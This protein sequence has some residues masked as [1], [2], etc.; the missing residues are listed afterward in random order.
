MWTGI[1][2]FLFKN[3][4]LLLAIVAISTIFMGF[5]ARKTSL[6]YTFTNGIPASNPVSQNFQ[7]LK[8]IFGDDASNMVLAFTKEDFFS[9]EFITD[10]ESFQKKLNSIEG[11]ENITSIINTSNLKISES[12]GEKKL[13]SEPFFSTEPN[14]DLEEV[15]KKV[16]K[17]KFYEGLLFNSETNAYL[18]LLGLDSTH[19]NSEQRNELMSSIADASRSFGEAHETDLKISGLPY[20]RTAMAMMVQNEMQ[21]F[22]ILSLIV[23]SLILIFLFRSVGLWLISLVYMGIGIIWG[24]G[25]MGILGFK[26]TLLTAL[27]APL[28]VIISV[29]NT[30]YFINK[31]HSSY[32]ETRDKS[33]SLRAMVEKIGIV[34]LFTNLTTA[35]GFGVFSLTTSQVL[36]EFGIVAGLTIVVLFI[37]A[38]I[39]LPIFLS[40]LPAPK[41]HQLKYMQNNWSRRLF[42]RIGK[43]V[44]FYRRALYV[45]AGV[46]V[47]IAILG[48]LRLN[49]SSYIVDDLPHD[50]KLYKDLVFFD[51][52]FG[53]VMPLEIIIDTRKKN[54]ATS[55]GTLN[56]TDRLSTYISSFPYISRPLSIV[57]GIKFA[58]QAYYD[59]EPS[60]YGMPNSLDISFFAPYLSGN[61]GEK[62]S[63]FSN[64]V[65]STK[66]YSRVSFRMQDIGTHR[67]DSF[68]AQLETEIYSVFDSSKYHVFPSGTSV[69]FLE[70]SKYIIS[71]LKSSVLLAFLFIFGCIFYLFK[72]WR[73]LLISMVVNLIPLVITAGIM[74]WVA[75]RIKPSTVLVF[76]IALGITVDMT[77]RFLINFKQEIEQNPSINLRK[78]VLN[79]ISEA[80][81]SIIFTTF[82]LAFGFGVFILSSFDGTRSLGILIPLT[83]INAMISNLTLLPALLLEMPQGYLN[84]MLG[85][86]KIL[87]D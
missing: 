47:V 24:F 43:L 3:K 21:Y 57:E 42:R 12:Q 41:T 59:G 35:L 61:Q 58:R 66:R 85:Q 64:F 56:K 14:Q 84:K 2:D 38:I 8:N 71:S 73:M 49:T 19:A 55:F 67:M 63:V 70:G 68:I 40:F 52:N 39:L 69:T 13:I 32:L 15:K 60:G 44:I 83:I 74:G 53:G 80:G 65:D 31:Y 28:V 25:I 75:I 17:T 72:N 27:L 7:T 82:I 5:Q 81:V 20:I 9:K 29:P 34:T 33:K 26:I 1:S 6:S 36:H 30:I 46:T 77:I 50:N 79:T 16:L 87:K 54:K 4:W 23:T 18:L 11:V 48:I 78:A 10:L 37:L 22:L 62:A 45:I 86:N 76:S 51:Q